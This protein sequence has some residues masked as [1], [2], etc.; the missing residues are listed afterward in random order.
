MR[1][2]TKIERTI[3]YRGFVTKISFLVRNPSLKKQYVIMHSWHKS[4]HDNNELQ[5]VPPPAITLLPLNISE[6]WHYWPIHPPQNYSIPPM[7][8]QFNIFFLYSQRSRT[9]NVGLFDVSLWNC[10]TAKFRNS[11]NFSLCSNTTT[12]RGW[13]WKVFIFVLFYFCFYFS[14]I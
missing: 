6:S 2:V 13:L 1:F 10:P 12:K 3:R 14:L 7:R 8:T 11:C 9:F 4:W 5:Y